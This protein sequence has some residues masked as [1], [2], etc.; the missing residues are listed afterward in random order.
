MVFQHIYYANRGSNNITR[1]T[2]TRKNHVIKG[3]I[4]NLKMHLYIVSMPP[5]KKNVYKQ[6]S[7]MFYF[8]REKEKTIDVVNF[9][10]KC[11][12][13]RTNNRAEASYIC[14]NCGDCEFVFFPAV[15]FR[16]MPCSRV[17]QYSY[18]R[19][20]H[21]KVRLRRFQAVASENVPEKVY[22]IIKRDLLKRR[23][24]WDRVGPMPTL[25]NIMEI[26]KN[27]KLT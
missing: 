4:Y 18:K 3:G 11:Q 15:N 26:L 1:K 2:I 22:D 6:D 12:L 14:L 27:N 21:L 13:E 9:C 17:C 7:V 10:N 23:I 8:V 19:L 24:R 20:N 25:T 5:R 16:D